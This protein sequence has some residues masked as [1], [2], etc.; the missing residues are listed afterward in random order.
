MTI[1]TKFKI[2]DEVW[3]RPTNYIEKGIIESID[4]SARMEYGI[5]TR[6]CISYGVNIDNYLFVFYEHGLFSTKEEL[7][8]S[9]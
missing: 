2:G 5:I 1:D 7:L 3:V 6:K 9:L 8:K 4:V